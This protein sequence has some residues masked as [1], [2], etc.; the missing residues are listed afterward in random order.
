[1]VRTVE[2]F[3]PN[4]IP[5]YT[6]VDRK[7]RKFDERL[8][9]ALMIPNMIVSLSGPSKSGKTVL[10]HKVIDPDNLISLSG[11]SIRCAEDLWSNA[12]AWMGSPTERVETTGSKV[13]AEVGGKAGGKGGIPLLAQAEG[14]VSGKI[15]G[16]LSH[17][18]ARTFRQSGLHQVIDEI[19]GSGFVLFVDDFHYIP[20][21]YKGK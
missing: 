16:D 9:D 12:L 4:S 14:E 3:T 20:K 13:G 2:V 18:T 19:G 1:M 21:R 8:R 11:A 10:V 17:E 15:E 5:T 6:Y 7:T